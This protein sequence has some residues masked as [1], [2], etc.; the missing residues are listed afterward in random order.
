M[1]HTETYRIRGM[2][3][4]SCASIIEKSLKKVEGV[5]SAEVNIGTEKVKISFDETKTN[6]QQ[7]S[8]TIEPLGYSLVTD[9]SKSE[10]L[11]EL[12]SMQTKIF[13]I[14]PM[15]VVAIVIMAWSILAEFN[16]VPAFSQSLN[17][18]FN[19][20]LALMATYALFVVGKPYLLGF[21]RFL[22][23]G[24]ANMDSLIGIGT[25]AAFV[26]SIIVTVFREAVRPFVN[27][28]VTYFD[29]AIV[30]I[31]FI[32][33]GKYLEARAKLKTGDAIEK[34][35]NLQAK[36]ALVIRDG[37]EIEVSVDQVV[38][39]E[40]IIVKPAGKIPV[41]GVLVEG[42]SFVDESMIIQGITSKPKAH[43]AIRA[44][45]DNRS[46]KFICNS[47]ARWM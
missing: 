27:V 43:S 20:I 16:R 13:I 32:S 15:A 19:M 6:P 17:E 10:K 21:Y 30:V 34:L 22:R 11:T 23:Y 44:V 46:S 35:L 29:V 5:E 31:A 7:L 8:K 26:Y 42:S 39:G 37:K 38:H 24:K 41:D 18:S 9:Q 14:M 1:N 33:F 3:C 12:A 2:H 45:R 36:T 4:A 47:F 25:S 40:L 28:E